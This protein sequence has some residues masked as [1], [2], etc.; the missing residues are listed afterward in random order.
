MTYYSTP[1]SS[2]ELY[3]HGI[4]G[5]RWGVRRYQNEDGSL[6]P[7]GERHYYRKDGS[8]KR[9]GAKKLLKAYKEKLNRDNAVYVD[10]INEEDNYRGSDAAQRKI[11]TYRRNNKIDL[12]K[13]RQNLYNQTLRKGSKKAE[14]VRVE[15]ELRKAMNQQV[16]WKRRGDVQKAQEAWDRRMELQKKLNNL[17]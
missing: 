9:R 14:K 4:K 10:K 7:A 1:P 2:D 16:Y 11:D 8:L 3:H 17:R 5:M 6:T 13:Y 15:S 12:N